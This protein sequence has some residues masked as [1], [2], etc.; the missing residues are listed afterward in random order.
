MTKHLLAAADTDRALLNQLFVRADELSNGQPAQLG[1]IRVGIALTNT[2]FPLPV[3]P[4]QVLADAGAE[5]VNLIAAARG[6]LAEVAGRE[7]AAVVLYSS[8]TAGDA[9]ALSHTLDVPLLN[10]GD[11]AH[12]NPVR[13]LGD[14]YAIHQFAPDWKTSRTALLGNLKFSA[15]AHS[16]AELL[17]QFGTRLSFVSPAA[18]SMP[19]DLTDRMRMLAEEVEETNDLETT[20]RKT[21]VLYLAN[22]DP[23]R[24]EK[25]VYDKQKSFYTLTP[26][27]LANA[28]ENLVILGEWDGAADLLAPALPRVQTAH[29]AMLVA[30]VE[31][32]LEANG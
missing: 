12:E 13:A 14:A 16:L 26:E 4:L 18:L 11:G 25:K 2:A 8:P 32:A 29:R 7:R 3:D 19:Y 1:G 22:I 17:A 15:E 31:F 28:Q 23:L 9:L 24:V 27:T 30:L 6:Q 5:P 20:L 10:A 21:D